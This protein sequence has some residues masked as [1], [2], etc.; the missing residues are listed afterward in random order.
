ML[1]R[2]GVLW[3]RF[4]SGMLSF[5]NSCFWRSASDKCMVSLST[6]L[7]RISVCPSASFQSGGRSFPG[8]K[9]TPGRRSVPSPQKEKISFILLRMSCSCE[10]SLG[11]SRDSASGIQSSFRRHPGCSANTTMSIVRRQMRQRVRRRRF[12][13]REFLEEFT[14]PLLLGPHCEWR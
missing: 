10:S 2:L 13:A 1:V 12:T 8:C 4:D 3:A 9:H 7:L 5:R 14:R 11:V 6:E